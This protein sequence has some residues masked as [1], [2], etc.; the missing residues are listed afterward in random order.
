[1]DG[2]EDHE[3]KK[4]LVCT[5]CQR[6]IALGADALKLAAGVYGP[7]GL[8]P[9]KASRW[10]CGEECAAGYSCDEEIIKLPRRIP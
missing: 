8:V 4:R 1:M 2:A 5:H 10:F 9:L 6:E 3:E 7:R